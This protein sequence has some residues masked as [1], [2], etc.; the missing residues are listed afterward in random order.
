[1]APIGYVNNP[2]SHRIEPDKIRGPL[3]AELFRLYATGDYS[4][5]ALTH[6]SAD[7]GLT[8]SRTRRRL[9][10]SEVHAKALKTSVR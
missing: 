1:M 10:K 9:F 8:Q 5:K 4:L 2:A 3:T 6:K 7:I